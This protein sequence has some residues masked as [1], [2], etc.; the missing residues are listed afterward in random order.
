MVKNKLR[1]GLF[2]LIEWTAGIA[3]ICALLAGASGRAERC[4]LIVRL[5]IASPA[6]FHRDIE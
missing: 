2:A 6:G 5:P 4:T 1:F 3:V